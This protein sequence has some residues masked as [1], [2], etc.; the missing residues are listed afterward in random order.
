MSVLCLRLGVPATPLRSVGGCVRC[1]HGAAGKASLGL[2]TVCM[3][4]VYASAHTAARL[5]VACRFPLLTLRP[6][7]LL[8]LR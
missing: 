6:S 1:M 8:S 7:W 3:V 5:R 2:G 4:S